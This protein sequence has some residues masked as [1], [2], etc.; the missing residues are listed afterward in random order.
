MID[1]SVIGLKKAFEADK[2][3]LDGLSFDVNAG[4]RVGLLGRNGAGKTTL[5]KLIAGELTEDEGSIII[6]TGRS[7]GLIS[8][9]PSYP[10]DY[11]VIDVLRTAFRRL[12]SMREKMTELEKRMADGAANDS[13]LKAYG[14]LS[15]A[16]E[17]AGGYDTELEL[18]R[19]ANGLSIPQSQYNQ[20]FKALSGGEQ[21]RVNL[22]RLILEDTDILLL[23]EPTNHLDMNAVEWLED[24]LDRFRGTV[25]VISHD[26]YFLDRVVKRIIELKNGRAEFYSGN[27]SFYVREKQARYDEQLKRYQT[28]R[29]KISELE[30]A[31]RRLH[32]WGTGNKKLQVKAFAIEKR[33]E[34]LSVTERPV[35]E[36]T[37]KTRFGEREFHADDAILINGVSMSFGEKR[38]FSGLELRVG[39]SERIAITGD[40]GAGKTTLLRVI[41]GET[42]PDCG[43]VRIG[44]SVKPAYLPQVV[45]FEDQHRTLLD[46]LIYELGLSP[47]SAR[48][49]LGAFMFSGDDVF[50]PVSAL[51]GGERSRLKLCMLMNEDINLL[52]LDEPTNHLD[53]ASREW[54]EEALSDF[55][56]TLIFVSHDRYFINRFATRIWDFHN[57]ALYDFPGGFE[58]YRA[59]KESRKLADRFEKAAVK[60][61]KPKQ[62]REKSPEKRLAELEKSISKL[63]DELFKIEELAVVKSSD[64]EALMEIFERRKTINEQLDK[65]YKAWEELAGMLEG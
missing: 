1:I 18:V 12:T 45:S 8:Q 14:D 39:G 62:K 56:G 54:I 46:T 59:Y 25:I 13:D 53:I 36:R 2:N 65:L 64:Y 22:A 26:R 6:G 37:I 38:L 27:Y 49:R 15:A 44:P 23:D 60:E 40:N 17:A 58:E 21:T 11:T 7:V 47:Q 19:V 52:I 10:E 5:F 9:I 4:E 42:R 35:K 3:I 55:G 43:T 32:A 31:A 28:E 41:L 34:R 24:Y 51:S 63:E 57:G 33:I 29:K 16:F 50:K 30:E 61:T 48:N 20:P